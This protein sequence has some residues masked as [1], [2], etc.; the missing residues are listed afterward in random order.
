VDQLTWRKQL[1][2]AA[3][4]RRVLDNIVSS[5]CSIVMKTLPIIKISKNI[6]ILGKSFWSVCCL[7]LLTG[8][9]WNQHPIKQSLITAAVKHAH[10]LEL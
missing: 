5:H 10:V 7:I 2:G 8:Q 4:I 1:P 3:K 6:E 9:C